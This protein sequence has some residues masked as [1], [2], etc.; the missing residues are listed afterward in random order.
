MSATYE[1]ISILKSALSGKTQVPDSKIFISH[2]TTIFVGEGPVILLYPKSAGR[3]VMSGDDN[4]HT[5]SY[6]EETF[7]VDVLVDDIYN[8]AGVSNTIE[9][10]CSI[11]K[12]I[13][14]AIF[15]DR[16][17]IF[18]TLD[19]IG[20]EVKAY[21]PGSV[22]SYAIESDKEGVMLAAGTE[23][24]IVYPEHWQRTMRDIIV[25]KFTGKLDAGNGA[26]RDFYVET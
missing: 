17:E 10:L 2:P 25:N 3:S 26:E 15:S 5:S 8:S 6:M 14:L 19:A 1:I 7:S 22:G 11:K 23:I 24:R 18:E 20:I 12:E 13:E 4:F 16:Y 21:V 9:T